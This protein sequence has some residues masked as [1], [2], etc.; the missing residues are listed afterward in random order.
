MGRRDL[1]VAR[2]TYERDT[3]ALKFRSHIGW[4][5]DNIWAA[6]LGLTDEAR[7]LALLKL[8]DGPYRFPAFWGPGFD[9][10]PDHNWGGSGMI[11]LQE[12]LMQ[13]IPAEENATPDCE[14]A[15]KTKIVLF[16]AWPKSWDVHFKL[17]ASGG[18]TVEAT[19][20]G[21][22]VKDVRVSPRGKSV[23]VSAYGRS[24]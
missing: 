14:E 19:L 9:W 6:C 8:A 12:M 7:R 20:Q 5:Q 4:K 11:G 17:H 18:M 3:L 10:S 22:E 1:E 13:E 15:G 24:Y 16:P 21:G 23:Y 2:N